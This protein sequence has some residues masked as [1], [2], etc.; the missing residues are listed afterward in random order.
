M[1]TLCQLIHNGHVRA[2][3]VNIALALRVKRR[4]PHY[5]IKFQRWEAV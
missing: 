1:I 2:Q 4:Y 3:E 5:I